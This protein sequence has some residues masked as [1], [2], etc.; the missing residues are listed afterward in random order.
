LPSQENRRRDTVAVIGLALVAMIVRLAPLLR[1]DLSFGYIH[2]DSFWFIQTAAGMLRGCGFA[3][4]LN[5]TCAPAEIMRTPGYPLMLALLPNPRVMMMVQDLM[6]GAICLLVGWAGWR[7]W[8]VGAALIAEFF[9]AFD[10]PSIVFADHVM[11]E[12]LFQFL[13]VLAA[14]P[15]LLLVSGVIQDSKKALAVTLF[16][17]AMAGAAIM[18]RPIGILIPFLVP[19][20]FWF[21]PAPRSRRLAMALIAFSIPLLTILGWSARNY[22]VSGYFGISSGGAINLYFFRAAEVVAREN[23]AGLLETQDEMG[24]RLGVK[25]DRI[26]D[27]DV[28]SPQLAHRMDSLAKQVLLAHPIQA[29][30][31]TAETSVYIALFPMRTQ[32]AY[33]I[34]TTGGSQGWGLSAG[35]PSVSR[36]RSELDKML[37]SSVL[38]ALIAFQVLMIVAMWVGVAWALLRCLYTPA[39]YRV[40]TLYLTLV[41]LVL[42]VIGAGGE[43]DVRFREPVIPLLATVAALGYFP[44]LG[45]MRLL[46]AAGRPLLSRARPN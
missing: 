34:G 5:G 11:S 1:A 10:L 2:E 7:C 25:M 14:I 23:R 6:G 30:E 4:W 39:D 45:R 17:A 9:I 33:M 36:F 28:Q 3:R 27:A 8:G 41:A 16:S 44:V 32:L 43:A 26:Y 37:H 20:P 24:S 29:L 18:V 42:I 12:Q 35:T 22:A 31:M 19:I 21:V 40:W 15:P 46:K 13:L 38:S